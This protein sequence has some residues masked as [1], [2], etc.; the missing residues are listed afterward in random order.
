MAS[1][2]LL[3]CHYELKK[4]FVIP[5]KGSRQST[6]KSACRFVYVYYMLIVNYDKRKFLFSRMYPT[7]EE[8]RKEK[9]ALG[10]TKTCIPHAVPVLSVQ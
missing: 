6:L 5:R 4:Y 9:S 10:E 7:L 8:R 1:C 2:M 3:A